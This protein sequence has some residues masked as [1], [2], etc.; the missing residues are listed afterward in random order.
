M[1]G[2]YHKEGWR[3]VKTVQCPY[4][5]EVRQEGKRMARHILA[6]HREKVEEYIKGE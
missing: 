3:K 6:K 5:I 2:M 1:K 4:C